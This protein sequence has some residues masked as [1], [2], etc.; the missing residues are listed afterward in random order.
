MKGAKTG[1]PYM[2]AA[3]A[4]SLCTAHTASAQII[5]GGDE[6]DVTVNLSVLDHLGQPPTLPDLF[7]GRHSAKPRAAVRAEEHAEQTV[8][9]HRVGKAST[10]AKPHHKH[11]PI[12]QVSEQ[13][14][15]DEDATEAAPTPAPHSKPQ[16]VAAETAKSNA[17]KQEKAEKPVETAA[18]KPAPSPS[19]SEQASNQPPPPPVLANPLAIAKPAAPQA[20]AVPPA[21]PAPVAPPPVAAAPVA[22][23]TEVAPPAPAIAQA[24]V[25]QPP[26]PA[27]AT[28][29]PA[30]QQLATAV[31]PPP[32]H[33]AV[34][35]ET[36]YHKGDVL[37][38]VFPVNETRMPSAAQGEM[39]A[40]A[41]R[42]SRDESLS[43]QLMA[44]AQGDE[45]NTSKARRLSLS[46][47][48]EVRRVLMDLGVRSTRIEVRALG[49]KNDSDAP[50]D[51]V[52]AI[53]T[54]H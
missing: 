17:V 10:A 18:P 29:A 27:A 1:S 3:L 20:A 14:E 48:L 4:F 39:T 8:V 31:P 46:R 15:T 24:P 12:K 33:K 44:F 45:A 49:N 32:A 35:T 5:I 51:R 38:V 34:N 19:K 26:A 11:S 42:L 52:D 53:L 54:V 23:P 7:L 50:A 2:L 16:S 6:P 41:Q 40:L 13:V 9:Y 47:A 30:P 25:V 28:P 43:L 21:K 37:T 36:V 22:A